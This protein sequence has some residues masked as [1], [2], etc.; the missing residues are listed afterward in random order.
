MKLYGDP[1]ACST[2]KV[3]MT[4]A[5]KGARAEL[6]GME[7]S[8]HDG[9]AELPLLDHEGFRVGGASTVMRYLDAA[10]PGRRLCP[11]PLRERARMDEWLA[12][13][14]TQLEPAL[15]KLDEE[16]R[17]SPRYGMEPDAIRIA[18]ARQEVASSLA[19]I[20]GALASGPY[21]VGSRLTLADIAHFAS[22]QALV[23]LEQGTL[24]QR[25]PRVS[26][27][28]ARMRER[29]T[30]HAALAPRDACAWFPP[31]LAALCR[32]SR[33]GVALERC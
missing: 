25:F 24:L 31:G 19:R 8:R 27:Y 9:A 6:V 10:L 21:L 12:L 1:Q 13:E 32:T 5:E 28:R 18:E 11:E 7:L 16:L 14:S 20:E 33:L 3:L 30:F 26:A 17:E 22:L 23:E 29:S 2:R 4:L 15:H